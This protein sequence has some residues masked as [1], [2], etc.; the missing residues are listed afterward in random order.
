MNLNLFVA[1]GVGARYG[2]IMKIYT[3]R[4]R[5]G[6]KVSVNTPSSTSSYIPQY[7]VKPYDCVLDA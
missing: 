2:L 4:G 7:K 1:F 6:D 3:Q 5:D